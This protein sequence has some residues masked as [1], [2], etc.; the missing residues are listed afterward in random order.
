MK[1][2]LASC[3]ALVMLFWTIPA[4]ASTISKSKAQKEN[5][6]ASSMSPQYLN[7]CEVSNGLIPL[8]G[9]SIEIY[10]STIGYADATS[11]T[12]D[13]T[14]QR[15]IGSSWVDCKTWS[16]TSPSS[17]R[18]LVDMDIYYTVPNGTYRVF[19][20]HSVTAGG[21]TEYE[22]MFSDVVTISS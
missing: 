7:I 18:E 20:T 10:A 8:G 11:C 13:A 4:N 14:L 5:S 6:I 3:L 2:I 9:S 22:Y 16:A 19:T 17:H 1:K 12:V 21:I 15:K